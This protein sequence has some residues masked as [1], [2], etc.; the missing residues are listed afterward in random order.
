VTSPPTYSLRLGCISQ[1]AQLEPRR[2]I[3]VRSAL[4][5]AMDLRDIERV[6]RQ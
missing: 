3:W 6:E 2:Q 1:R 5:W 4:P